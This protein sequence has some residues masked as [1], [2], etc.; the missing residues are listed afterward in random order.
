MFD[1]FAVGEEP[2]HLLRSGSPSGDPIRNG[3]SA[4]RIT[5]VCPSVF[6]YHCRL[7]VALRVLKLLLVDLQ[8]GV[9]FR[10]FASLVPSLL[11]QQP[12]RCT[13]QAG[14]GIVP[15]K[16]EQFGD[17]WLS[18]GCWKLCRVELA[19]AQEQ[20]PPNRYVRFFVQPTHQGHDIGTQRGETMNQVA[21][22]PR[23]GTVLQERPRPWQ[24]GSS[25]RGRPLHSPV[26]SPMLLSL[27]RW[28]RASASVHFALQQR[29]SI[30]AKLLSFG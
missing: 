1:R 24:H 3:L 17:Q 14:I 29:Q 12:L 7:S 5:N 22:Y 16:I 23:I 15:V 27:P 2:R 30:F 20:G 25:S 13:M 8:L 4:L 18:L 6:T 9:D 11:P 19:Q 10:Q 26:A 21:P 28:R